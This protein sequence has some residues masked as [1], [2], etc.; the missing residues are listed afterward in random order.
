MHG[1]SRRHAYKPY[2]QL[3]VKMHGFPQSCL[4]TLCSTACKMHGS[5]QTCLQALCSTASRNAW[6]P[7]DMLTNPMFNCM[8]K[9]MKSYRH[10]GQSSPEQPRAVQNKPEQPRAAQSSR[11][12]SR[13]DQ[14]SSRAPPSSPQQPRAAQSSPEQPRAAQNSPEHHRSAPTVKMHTVPCDVCL[15]ISPTRPF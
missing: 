15:A 7:T 8:Q 14:S 4:Q 2:V 12:Q 1:G 5:P 13:A 3:H 6:I 11:E 9:C 10:V